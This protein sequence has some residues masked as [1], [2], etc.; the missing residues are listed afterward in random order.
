MFC[1]LAKIGINQ[2]SMYK[3][4]YASQ[5]NSGAQSVNEN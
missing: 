1:S 3:Y 4:M 5:H 2:Y